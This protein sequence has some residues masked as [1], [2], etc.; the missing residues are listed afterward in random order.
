MLFLHKTMNKTQ[1]YI[2]TLTESKS[3]FLLSKNAP[4]ISGYIFMILFV[5]AMIVYALSSFVLQRVLFAKI[6]NIAGNNAVS[7]LGIFS[8]II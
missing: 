2:P 1:K 4:N 5:V 8:T 7:E 3:L 6:K